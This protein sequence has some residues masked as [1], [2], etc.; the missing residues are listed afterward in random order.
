MGWSKLNQP[1]ALPQE[2]QRRS[3]VRK[4]P[5]NQKIWAR[6]KVPV[7]RKR[8][9]RS[10]GF[11]EG[12][13]QTDWVIP[14][15][16]MDQENQMIGM[17]Q[18]DFEEWNDLN[19]LGNSE[20]SRVSEESE[21][22]KEWNDSEKS[23]GPDGIKWFCPVRRFQRVRDLKES[24]DS[25]RL[26][27]SERLYDREESDEGEE[28]EGSK[29][30]MIWTIRKSSLGNTCSQPLIEVRKPRNLR[31]EVCWRRKSGSC[32]AGD[33]EQTK[34]QGLTVPTAWQVCRK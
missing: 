27:D 3:E 30:Q 15:N 12:T 10:D 22:W 23:I 34:P 16:Q 18:V 13:I 14:K 11:E 33:S 2:D 4:N 28:L 20:R 26:E 8:S 1:S 32:V 25:G 17:D 31:C 7:N 6:W 5:E 29:N 21:D 24:N 19:G 9:E